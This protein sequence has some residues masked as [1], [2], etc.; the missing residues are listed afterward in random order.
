[1]STQVSGTVSWTT[2]VVI[3]SGDVVAAAD[4]TAL[5]KDVAFLRAAPWSIINQT[6]AGSSVSAGGLQVLF[7]GTGSGTYSTTSSTTAS[8]TINNSSG[9]FSVTLAGMY[10]ISASV[11]VATANG[12]HFRIRLVGQ[13]SGSPVWQYVGSVM[14]G[15]SG[16]S[17]YDISNISV[18]VPIG[19]ATSSVP[20]GNATSF[21]VAVDCLSGSSAIVPL[22]TQS[23]TIFPTSIQI[24]YTGTSTGAY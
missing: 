20:L 3:N 15:V 4:L 1:M 14:N 19:T 9:T 10:R 21:Y 12:T 23:T 7:G 5:N 6:G 8:G 22:G 18:L 17:S 24:E 16:V 11:G 2:P 13:N